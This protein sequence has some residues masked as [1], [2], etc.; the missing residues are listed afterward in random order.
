[1]DTL[2]YQGV[3]AVECFRTEAGL[4][5]NE[6]A[7]RVHNSG[8]WSQNGAD[9]SQFDLHLYALLNLPFPSTNL[10]RHS[11]MLNL[12]GCE[13]NPKWLKIA[14]VHC[15]WYGKD[16]RKGRK[17]G[18]LNIQID[19]DTPLRINQLKPLLDDSHQ[20]LLNQF[21]TAHQ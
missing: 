3:M 11:F 7:P 12:I 9:H 4:I 15:H 13:F 21:T 8:H 5:V 19:Q 20:A 18:H 16:F 10:T 2:N 14:G 1:M 17:L 6:V